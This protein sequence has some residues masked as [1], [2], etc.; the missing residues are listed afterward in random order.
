MRLQFSLSTGAGTCEYTKLGVF[1][2]LAAIPN[3]AEVD[4]FIAEW[5]G[6]SSTTT[7]TGTPSW[8]EP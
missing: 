2:M 8:S 7:P 4:G 5:L 6:P 1:R 3:L